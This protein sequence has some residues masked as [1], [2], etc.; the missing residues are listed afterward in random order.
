MSLRDLQKA[1]M[2]SVFTR[3][4]SVI[5]AYLEAATMSGSP[6]MAIYRNNIYVALTKALEA[7]Y[8]V[9]QRLVGDE[10]FKF[11]ARRYIDAHPSRSGDLNRFGADLAEFL[12]TFEHAASLPYLPD[13]ARLEWCCHQAYSAADDTPLDLPKLAAVPPEDYGRLC[14]RLNH[15]SRLLRSAWPIDAIWQV[16]QADYTGDQSVD[17]ASGGVSLLLQRRENRMVLM[18]L[19]EAEWGFLN[20]LNDRQPL[21]AAYECAMRAD[22]AA[23]L[24][25]LLHTYVGQTTLVEFFL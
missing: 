15:A 1:F 18:T 6:H 16:N 10:F 25:A 17:L 11:A 23:D 4:D 8:P 24:G 3:D 12:G 9:I 5:T 7:I 13:V 2:S 19:S 22:P 21:N 20:T 14:F